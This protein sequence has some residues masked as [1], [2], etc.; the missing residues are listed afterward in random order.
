MTGS[1]RGSC[2]RQSGITG[3][4]ID[5]PK[6]DIAGGRLLHA[7]ARYAVVQFTLGFEADKHSGNLFAN[8]QTRHRD[9]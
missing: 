7:N 2:R 3:V 4:R 8:V 9:L 6:A 1:A 5:C